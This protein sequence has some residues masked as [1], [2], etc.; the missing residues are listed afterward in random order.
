MK[1]LILGGTSFYGKAMARLFHEAGHAV[2]LFTRGNRF[3]QDLPPHRHIRGDRSRKEDLARAAREDRWDILVDNIAY[4]GD[5]VR[6]ALE[7]FPD[8]KRYLLC[9]TVSVYR[10]APRAPQPLLESSV[11]FEARPADENPADVHWKYARGKLE[12][13]RAT[14]Q[15]RVPWTIL[16]PP[17]IYGPHDVTNRGFWYLGRAVKGGPVLLANDGT[18]SFRLAYSIDCARAFVQCASTAK[19]EGKVY[20]VAHREIITLKDFVLD[21]TGALG[22]TP[23][24]LGVPM[25]FLG[26]LAGP[27]ANMVN[28][29]PD[30]TAA[31]RDFGFQP[32]PWREVAALTARWFRDSWKGD[33]AALYATREEELRLARA[34]RDATAGLPRRDWH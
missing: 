23:E 10:F 3:P 9:S 17:V 29:V 33:A 21:G 18:H 22:V 19:T 4:T 2:T 14:M 1:V 11:D 27:Y 26:E 16:R 25:E 6:L 7:L 13:E 20:N 32:T 30:F 31:E 12:A 5:E 24:L 15:A 8:V 28:F 34:F